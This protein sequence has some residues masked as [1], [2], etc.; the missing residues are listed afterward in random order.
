MQSSAASSRLHSL[1]EFRHH[2]GVQVH[3]RAAPLHGH[4]KPRAMETLV[5]QAVASAVQPQHLEPSPVFAQKDEEA[6]A[7]RKESLA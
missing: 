6:A 1:E 5:E 3:A 2:M 7:L 4:D